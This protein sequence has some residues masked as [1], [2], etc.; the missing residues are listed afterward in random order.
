[1]NDKHYALVGWLAI[2]SAILTLPSVALGLLVEV[3]RKPAGLL[4]L[5]PYLTLSLA[6]MAFSLYALYRLRNLLNDR[7]QFHDVDHLIVAIIFGVIALTAVGCVGKVAGV[8]GR[9]L[10]IRDAV[11]LPFALTMLAVLVVIGIATS[12]L[13]IVFGVKLLRLQ[14]DLYGLLKPFVWCTIAAAVCFV[15]LILAPLGGLVDAAAT[16]LLGIIFLRAARGIP[17]PEFV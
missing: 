4:L 10:G 3:I 1:M 7:Y 16:I 8:L 13:S 11:I 5:G 15:T 12:I 14:D 6:A 17:A 9:A 2:A